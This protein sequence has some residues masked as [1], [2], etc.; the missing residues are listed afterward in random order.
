MSNPSYPV[1]SDPS[2]AN[3]HPDQA[4]RTPAQGE[5]LSNFVTFVRC[6]MVRVETGGYRRRQSCTP[7]SQVHT[8]TPQLSISLQS[9]FQYGASLGRM[10]RP[11]VKVTRPVTPF[12]TPAQGESLSEIVPL[13]RCVMV[14]VET[15]GHRRV[16]QTPVVHSDL[17][18]APA[19][20][21]GLQ[22]PRGRCVLTRFCNYHISVQ[23]N[24]A[25]ISTHQHTPAH[26]RTHQHTVGV[27]WGWSLER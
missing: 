17:N 16:P 23:H 25:H 24:P 13:V 22:G 5:Y 2:T 7:T 3:Q 18:R 12:R 8:S 27:P 4:F 26:I 21:P 11:P 10:M 14:R 6:V 20:G 15:G 9:A 1:H 19:P